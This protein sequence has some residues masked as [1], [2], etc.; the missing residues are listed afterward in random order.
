[1]AG[2]K[3]R[4]GRRAAG[5]RIYEFHFYYRLVPGQDPPELEALLDSIVAAKGRKRGDIIRAALLGGAGQAKSTAERV[6]DS[7]ISN[8]FDEMFADF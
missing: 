4:S 6:E 2:K 7:E 1:M 3:G 5:G 8:L